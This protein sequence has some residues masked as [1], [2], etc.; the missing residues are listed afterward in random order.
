GRAIDR[1]SETSP[2]RGPPAR[3]ARGSLCAHG[4]RRWG[5]RHGRV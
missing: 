2:D 3:S 4:H 1:P 5:G